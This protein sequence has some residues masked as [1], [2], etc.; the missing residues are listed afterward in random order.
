MGMKQLMWVGA[1]L[2]LLSAILNIREF[3]NHVSLR[4]G[5]QVL[6]SLCLTL[7]AV[8]EAYRDPTDETLKRI[9]G[10]FSLFGAAAIL[11]SLM[12]S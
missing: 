9:S 12:V 3:S 6:G 11:G 1:G 2:F 5:L 7:F 4:G 8:T 10:T